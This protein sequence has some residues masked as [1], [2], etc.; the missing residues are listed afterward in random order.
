MTG[1]RGRDEIAEQIKRKYELIEDAATSV[2][3]CI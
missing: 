1:D 3:H 2:S